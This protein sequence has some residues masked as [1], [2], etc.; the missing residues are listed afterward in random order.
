[1]T[2]SAIQ[3][4]HGP[5]TRR[6][7]SSHRPVLPASVT[8]TTRQNCPNHHRICRPASM[9]LPPFPT[10]R[11]ES[12]EVMGLEPRR[13]QYQPNET[14][15]SF[16]E[17]TYLTT[18]PI[19]TLVISFTTTSVRF[20]PKLMSHCEKVTVGAWPSARQRLLD[21]TRRH[22]SKTFLTSNIRSAVRSQPLGT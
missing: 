4:D 17:T 12:S 1:M 11:P 16:F 9:A 10:G 18:T 22:I 19:I 6:A 20:T 2:L 7:T 15:F 8:E 13:V 3:P 5:H 21:V 14:T